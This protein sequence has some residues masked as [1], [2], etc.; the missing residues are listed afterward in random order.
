M[1]KRKFAQFYEKNW[2]WIYFFSEVFLLSLMVASF[3]TEGF[4]IWIGICNAIAW[5]VCTVLIAVKLAKWAHKIER[6]EQEEICKKMQELNL[7]DQY[8]IDLVNRKASETIS[9]FKE[10]SADLVVKSD[11]NIY[12]IPFFMN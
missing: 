11:A 1:K 12:L 5:V 9:K 10:E 7:Q 3:K 4:P 2:G 8:Y 6:K